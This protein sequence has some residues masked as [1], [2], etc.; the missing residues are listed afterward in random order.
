[1]NPGKGKGPDRCM[2]GRSGRSCVYGEGGGKGTGCLSGWNS[3]LSIMG[4]GMKDRIVL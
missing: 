3:A 2:E 1:M 4:A